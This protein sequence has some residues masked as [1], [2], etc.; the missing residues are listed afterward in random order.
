M[1]RFFILENNSDGS[2]ISDER[3]VIYGEDA[4]H[5][6]KALRM[7]TGEG[8]TICDGRGNDYFG[9]ISQVN[10]DCVEIA[11]TNRAVCENEAE[12]SVTLYQGYPKGDKLEFVIEK[13]VELGAVEI[14]PVMTARSVAR[15]DKASADKKLTRWRRHALEAAKQSGRGIVPRV[16]EL[17]SFDTLPEMIARHDLTLFCYEGG[18]IP[19]AEAVAQDAKNIGIIIGPEGGF[20]QSEADALATCGAK[21]ISLGGRILRTET[22]A[23]ATLAY[24]LVGK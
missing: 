21:I 8:I 2:F 17:T 12:I 4:R 23:V 24:L 13:A 5:I 20:E 11:I 18:G 9:E 7:R 10:G 3:A 6:G 16:S 14:V 1:P 22:A 15:P 19:I